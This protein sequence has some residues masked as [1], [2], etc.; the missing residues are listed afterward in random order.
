MS[1][2]S[3]SYQLISTAFC[4]IVILSN[5]ISV[6]MVPLPFFNDFS[7]PAGLM[8]Y[9]LTFLLS[10]LVTEIFGAKKA[11]RMVYI[12][13][14]MNILAL[15]I[16]Q[17]ALTMPSQSSEEHAI[18]QAV[19][20]LSGLRIFSSLAAYTISQIACIRIYTL[21]KQWTGLK[22][23]WVRANGSTWISQ[24]IDTTALDLLFFYWGVGMGLNQVV[25]IIL[26]SFC[27]KVAFSIALTPL[28]YLL[29]SVLKND[30]IIN[31][32]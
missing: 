3:T 31:A 9:P 2:L 1:K 16:L 7:I 32:P 15:S 13:L 8:T 24:L 17:V 19:L 22:F 30:K 20:G 10:D 23:L 21:L 6:K 12:T 29:V 14:G 18:F 27:Y 11:K 28:F 26:F 5:I 25:P 4:V